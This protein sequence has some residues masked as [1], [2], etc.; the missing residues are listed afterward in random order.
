METGHMHSTILDNIEIL[1]IDSHVSRDEVLCMLGDAMVAK[2]W[3]KPGLQDAIL[4]REAKFPTGLQT[5]S[6]GIAIPHAD[7]EWALEP[8]MIVGVLENP[9]EFEPMAGV[10]GRVQVSLVFLI[11]VVE[12]EAHI[13]FL[14][15]FTKAIQNDAKLAEIQ[16]AEE[17]GVLA[18]IIRSGHT[19]AE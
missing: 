4:A 2:G 3:A 8:S 15:T 7:P 11:A 5:T 6:I 10:G 13:G 14:Q 17:A 9:V 1:H 18:E 16:R 12:P 19:G